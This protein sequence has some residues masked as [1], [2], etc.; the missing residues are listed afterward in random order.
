MRY[1][2]FRNFKIVRNCEK[3]YKQYKLY[4]PYL[5]EDFN[6][7][8]AYCNMHDKFINENYH[9]DHFIPQA[10]VRNT[11]MECLIY[12]YNNLMY[13][14][15]K[16][17]NAKSSQYKGNVH[18][19]TY[20]NE[21]FYNPVDVDYNEIF[22]RNEYGGISS[23]DLKGREMIINLKLFSPIHN[24]SFLIEEITDV[25]NK[26]DKKIG[27]TN[28]LVEKDYYNQSYRKLNIFLLRIKDLFNCN[29]YNNSIRK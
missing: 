17:N 22:Y 16:C 3:K 10:A 12:D 26:I 5:G 19:G 11:D 20:N 21:L 24:L 7:R 2:E 28:D 15:P 18:D 27:E 8:C 4:L 6:H 14:C 25:L 23:E 1:K 13:S 29:Y 9:V